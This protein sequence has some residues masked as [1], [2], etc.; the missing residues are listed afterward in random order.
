MVADFGLPGLL[1]IFKT[2]ISEAMMFLV[3]YLLIHG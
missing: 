3:P 2:L 1:A